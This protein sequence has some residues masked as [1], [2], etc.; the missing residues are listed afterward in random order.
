MSHKL[1]GPTLWTGVCSPVMGFHLGNTYRI[2][3]A[4]GARLIKHAISHSGPNIKDYIVPCGALCNS[5]AVKLDMWWDWYRAPVRE[6]TIGLD[7]PATEFS[8][9]AWIYSQRIANISHYQYSYATRM[10]FMR[11]MNVSIFIQRTNINF[12]MLHLYWCKYCRAWNWYLC[13]AW[14]QEILVRTK[15]SHEIF[16]TRCQSLETHSTTYARQHLSWVY[17]KGVQ[18]F[19]ARFDGRQILFMLF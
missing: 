3:S 16:A 14:K 2:I 5:S 13:G 7:L 6:D 15:Y 1:T 12:T 18:V 11:L 9:A 8:C 17:T 19:S 10:Y 4:N